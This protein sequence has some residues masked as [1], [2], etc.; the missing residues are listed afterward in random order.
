MW[1]QRLITTIL[2]GTRPFTPYLRSWQDIR[3]RIPDIKLLIIL[4]LGILLVV[5]Q[6]WLQWILPKVR[7]A[8]KKYEIEHFL[9][10]SYHAR[11]DAEE[12]LPYNFV[13]N[14]R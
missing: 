9:A 13:G 3:H 11:V 12:H 5:P 4:V 10:S 6:A 8:K 2:T 1:N 14:V 7:Y